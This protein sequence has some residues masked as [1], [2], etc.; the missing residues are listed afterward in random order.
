VA[1]LKQIKIVGQLWMALGGLLSLWCAIEIWDILTSK[2][3]FRGAFI[4]TLMGLSFSISAY[5]SGTALIRRKSW[6]GDAIFILSIIALLYG[7]IYI[8]FAGFEDRGIIYS[9][10]VLTVIIMSIYSIWVVSHK[11]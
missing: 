3:F 9:I 11:N 8:L 2:Y 4:A 10:V 1:K 5:I 7:A 6:G